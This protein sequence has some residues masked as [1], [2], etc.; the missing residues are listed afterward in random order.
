LQGGRKRG[1]GGVPGLS[2]G[3]GKL[4]RPPG[5][6]ELGAAILAAGG[7]SGRESSTELL[8]AGGGR[9]G[10]FAKTPLDFRVFSGNFKTGLKSLPFGY[11]E[12]FCNPKNTLNFTENI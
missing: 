3:G 4:Y 5:A 6:A 8:P 7:I 12:L 11:F 1:R 2:C 10:V 9:K